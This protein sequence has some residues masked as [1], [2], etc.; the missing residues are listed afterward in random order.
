MN[1]QIAGSWNQLS[2]ALGLPLSTHS[3]IPSASK[4]QS[5]L[6]SRSKD[7]FTCPT[8][9]PRT[10]SKSVFKTHIRGVTARDLQKIYW[11]KCQDLDLPHKTD[12]EK[13]FYS[14][15]ASC[16]SSRKIVLN[17]A[18]IGPEAAKTLGK[19]LAKNPPYGSL[20]LSRNSLG[21]RGL[22]VLAKYLQRN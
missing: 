13:R 7:T 10:P 16:F 2:L 18:G 3:S 21:D 22:L 12:L 6:I 19:L 1:K 11:A 20:A 15:C 14:Y 8:K 5:R 4:S 9:T 17:E